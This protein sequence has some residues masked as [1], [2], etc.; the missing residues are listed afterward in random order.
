MA[1]ARVG[2]NLVAFVSSKNLINAASG[3][4]VPSGSIDYRVSVPTRGKNAL[5]AGSS[6]LDT[7]VQM[8]GS[9]D[10]SLSLATDYK[11]RNAPKDPPVRK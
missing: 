2:Q 6:N 5:N 10:L 3:A 7:S 9:M 11:K 1:A 8:L 4:L